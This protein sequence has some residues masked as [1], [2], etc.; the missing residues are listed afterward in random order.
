M[1]WSDPD[2]IDR[3]DTRPGGGRVL[4]DDPVEAVRVLPPSTPTQAQEGEVP[5]RVGGVALVSGASAGIGRATA[6]R[7]AQAGMAV[8]LL[9]RNATRL[10]ETLAEVRAAGVG[11]VALPAD[12]T[13]RGEV[14][15]AVGAVVRDLGPVD[16]LVCNAGVRE[17]RA[18]P[19]WQADPADWWRAVE[20]SLR[21]AFLLDHA[22]LPS[23]IE[24]GHGR[25]LH[26][27][28][29][30]G[31][32]P[33]PSYSGYAVGKAG[34]SRLTDSMAVALRG[35]GVVVLEASPGLVRT[36]MTE[37]MWEGLEDG[38]YGSVEPFTDLVLAFAAGR[39]DGLHGRFLHAQRDDLGG[40]RAWAGWIVERDARTLRLRPYGVDDPL[41]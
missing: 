25:V 24:R 31:A 32:R 3:P 30:V 7:L 12:V 18:S 28:S 2:P 8:G 20:V 27:S 39:L 19:P 9:G 14:E 17:R 15:A 41:A 11:G 37:G 38:A 35:S 34:L 6:L 23:M 36:A 22:V 21:G 26:V 40:L 5:S 29:G 33:E 4:H 1:N 10:A 13:E 16:L